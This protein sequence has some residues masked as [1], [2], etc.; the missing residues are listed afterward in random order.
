MSETQERR[1]K[2]YCTLPLE[3]QDVYLVA[4][5]DVVKMYRLGQF[6]GFVKNGQLIVEASHDVRRP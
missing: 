6:I 4:E 2:A 5:Q 3:Y 1:G